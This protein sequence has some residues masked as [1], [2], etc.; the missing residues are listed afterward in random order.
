MMDGYN[1]SG[2]DPSFLDFLADSYIKLEILKP[3]KEFDFFLSSI[4]I[5]LFCIISYPLSMFWEF[6]NMVFII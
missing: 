5:L 6:I 4:L 2:F 1:G 3:Y